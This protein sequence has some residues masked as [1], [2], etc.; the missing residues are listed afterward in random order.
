M[1]RM[2]TTPTTDK[3][4]CWCGKP[5]PRGDAR[6]GEVKHFV[7]NWKLYELR[8]DGQKKEAE[9]KKD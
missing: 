9:E 6:N 4:K 3:P 5:H 8:K 1:R 2:A 7:L